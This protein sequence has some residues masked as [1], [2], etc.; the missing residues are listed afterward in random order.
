MKGEVAATA[1]G[2]EHAVRQ[3]LEAPLPG[4]GTHDIVVARGALG[5][6]G[7][8]I[9]DLG[10][11]PRA[12]VVTTPAVARHWRLRLEESLAR[13]G[14]AAHW[15]MVPDGEAA[16]SIEHAQSLYAEAVAAGLDRDSWI[17]ALGGGVVGDLAGFVAATFLRGVHLLQAPTTLLAQVDASIGG[18]NGVN[19]PAGKNL[20][21]TFHWPRRVLADLDTLF[22]LPAAEFR[23]GL[24]EAVKCGLIAGGAYYDF[25][26]EHGPG[27]ARAQASQD[28]RA[29]IDPIALVELV[30]GSIRTKAAIVAADPHEAGLRRRLN[31]GH[32]VA[33]ALEAAGGFTQYR[34][35]EAVG[36]GLLAA[37]GL[38]IRMGTG[39]TA[40]HQADL[41]SLLLAL[42]LPTT[43]PGGV[44][45]RLMPFL[46][47][48][49]KRM[50]GRLR[51]ILP[52]S[53]GRLVERDDVP[54]EAVRSTIA[55]EWATQG[56]E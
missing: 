5:E 15:A 35:G 37:G 11:T 17:V 20:V 56:P 27:L 45:D 30:V 10:G 54:E 9:R 48:D 38:A 24:A 36:L 16:K 53:P 14:V 46:A 29:A 33:H 7:P 8:S 25:I 44:A 51:W 49:K 12:L 41:R 42:G 50:A 40:A 39:W 2:R 43:V 6:A 55:A 23:A 47:R 21:G 18:K 32:T 22:T 28:G 13:A 34:H 3:V 31:L 4:G 26:R 52:E 1:G 19:L